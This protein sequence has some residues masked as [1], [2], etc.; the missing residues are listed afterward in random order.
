[1]TGC[2]LSLWE[3]AEVSLLVEA[4]LVAL[5]VEVPLEVEALGEVGDKMMSSLLELI[6]FDVKKL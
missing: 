5:L 6:D 3:V 2:L 1:M 4:I